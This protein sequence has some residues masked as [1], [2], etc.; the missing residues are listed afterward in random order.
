VHLGNVVSTK[1]MPDGYMGNA[2][3]GFF[4]KLLA[5][6]A[7]LW[8]WGLC[9]WFFIV[10]VGAHWQVI[11]HWGHP[12]HHIHFDMTW[13]SFVF[14]NTAMITAT[15]AVGKTFEVRAIQILGTAMTVLLV[16]VWFFVFGM[17]LRAFFLQKLLWPDLDATRKEME[18]VPTVIEKTP[19]AQSSAHGIRHAD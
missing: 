3:A 11:F 16:L 19:T 18:R 6:L 1:I 8:M 12:E 17:M 4:L 7:G 14:P 10:S 2:S 9:L 5:D 13:Y 15:Q